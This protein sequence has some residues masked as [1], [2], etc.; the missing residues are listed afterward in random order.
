MGSLLKDIYSKAFY[1]RFCEVVATV[2][3]TFSKQKFLQFI[4]D[5]D[6]Q[7]MELKERMRHTT[8]ALHQF[9]PGNFEK[10]A[11]MIMQII[12][13]LRKNGMKESG[14]EYMFLPDYIETYG[15][16]HYDVSVKVMEFITQFTSCEFAVRPFLVKY[17]EKMIGQMHQWSLH[18]NEKVR[19]LASEGSRPRLPWAMAV[20][21][22]KKD[23]SPI[24]PI[25]EKLKNDPSET[26]RR[27]VANSLNDISKDHPAMVTAIA[28]RWKGISKET[29]AVIRHACRT[30]LKQAHP[31]MMAYYDLAE[32]KGIKL[33]GFRINTSSVKIGN[34]LEFSFTVK[35]TE[36]KKQTVRLEYAIF[37]RK[38]N[39][40]LSRKVFKISER[41]YR[42]KEKCEVV[43]RQSF[44]NIT[45][46][47]FY[48]GP[49]KVA[50]IINGKEQKAGNFE[51]VKS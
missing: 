35:N 37:Y 36:E 34:S 43:R 38:H 18:E 28:Q 4:F 22:L 9:L 42:A 24:L 11:K 39:G 19:R 23:P 46:R 48:P 51:L 29:D 49:H 40:Q 16:D 17:G 5:A 1:N 6:W 44:K 14:I 31:E 21:A 3:P 7:Q 41:P 10:A 45:T 30:L 2:N 25:L 26:V 47:R 20:P 50:I 32:S 13:T 33:S 15:I 12:T 8:L 27:S